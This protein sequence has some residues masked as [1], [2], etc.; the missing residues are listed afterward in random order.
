MARRFTLEIIEEDG[1]VS[2]VYGTLP[3]SSVPPDAPTG[4]LIE[5]ATAGYVSLS[6]SGSGT[7]FTVYRDGVP[8]G[9]ASTNAYT[10]STVAPSTAY[11]Y[12]VQA[13][14]VGGSSALSAALAITT[15]ANTPAVWSI[16]DQSAI[17]GT[18]FSLDLTTVC[19]DSDAQ[20]LVFTIAA[21][22]VPGL[23]I[24]GNVLTGTP[25]VAAATSL[26][27]DA[28]DGYDHAQATITFTVSD[29]DVT[30]PTVPS[31]VTAIA[32]GST[33]TVS[34]TGSTDASGV[35]RYRIYR[36]GSFRA[37]DTASPYTE[38]GVPVGSYS[39][40]VSAVDSSANAN[41]SAQSTAALVT[42]APANPDTPIN[43]SAAAVSATQINLSWAAGPNGSAP[44]DY[45]LDFSTT[46]ASGPWTSLAFV[47]AGTT[48]SHTGRTAGVTVYYRL[49]AGLGA[50]ESGYATTSGTPGAEYFVAT[51]AST[52]NASALQGGDIITVRR[53]ASPR[54]PLKITGATGTSDSR[55]RIRN[56][57]GGLLTISGSSGFILN[58][59]NC[60]Y[61][62]A[63]FDQ[64]MTTETVGGESIS[65]GLLVTCPD[66]APAFTSLIKTSGT[67]SFIKISNFK[68]DGK[69][70]T[71]TTGQSRV[72]IQTYDTIGRTKVVGG[73][74]VAQW[75]E[76]IELCNFYIRRLSGE[77]IYNGGN[78][79][80]STYACLRNMSTHDG[81]IEDCGREAIQT[82]SWLT[83][84]NSIHDIT[85][86]RCGRNSDSSEPDQLAGISVIDGQA[87]IYNCKVFGSGGPGIQYFTTTDLKSGQN[88]AQ[89]GSF[90][91]FVGECY[92]NV[93]YDS[94]TVPISRSKHGIAVG[95]AAGSAKQNV[96]VYSNTCV[97][98]RGSG[99]D[100]NGN[101]ST[102]C[103]AENNILLGN[104]SATSLS[105]GGTGAGNYTGPG[106]VAQ[107]FVSVA[108]ENFHL[109]TERSASGVKGTD[110]SDND[111][112][113]TPRTGTASR[114]A[115]EYS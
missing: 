2:K 69:W 19:E 115:Y 15:P 108:A 45:D 72:G 71:Y 86:R 87:D 102:S 97:S 95:N 107:T 66:A 30:A 74:T 57:A 82:K 43:F 63:V 106:T 51:T 11:S 35:A 77:G 32:N 37:T 5:E 56:E 48:Y 96:H 4:L 83:G 92:N 31:N 25:T 53:S 10:D 111:I 1:R 76:S 109:L 40:T 18:A 88:Y 9:S 27:L 52:F 98:N 58:F 42:V 103:V 80:N 68:L 7:T 91:E 62:D 101:A 64:S 29:P 54:G 70:T 112:E 33:V 34:W 14:D 46:S 93:T 17:L 85:A 110:Y 99:V 94:G 81:I 3:A 47:G 21:G 75:T 49:R 60:R 114:G 20:T 78:F 67:T 105:V 73:S 8:L 38:T 22:A 12:Q 89:Y 113:G 104:A 23:S 100:V 55:I 90:T 16:L 59:E 41:E 24:V 28:F 39:Y 79:Y 65:Y 84:V 50:A 13:S 6:W 44:D 36:N 61:V 26:T